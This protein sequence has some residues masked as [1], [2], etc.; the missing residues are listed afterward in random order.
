MAARG[1]RDFGDDHRTR[2]ADR[3]LV[4]LYEIIL[5][6]H[7]LSTTGFEQ[8]LAQIGTTMLKRANDELAEWERRWRPSTLFEEM[9]GVPHVLHALYTFP[10]IS[11][12]WYRI[13]LNSA[14]AGARSH[15]ESQMDEGLTL[16]KASLAIAVEAAARMLWLCA[17]ESL[18]DNSGKGYL[19]SSTQPFKI[20]EARAMI[21]AYSV[22]S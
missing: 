4:D 12:S 16:L 14:S 15:S 8:P 1:V 21:L 11:L 6:V 22:D 3:R 5:I 13:A 20:N 17:E 2:P 9:E 7:R 19:V 18:H 10:S